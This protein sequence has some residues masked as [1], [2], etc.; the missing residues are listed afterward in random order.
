MSTLVT[1]EDAVQEVSKVKI[2][3][4]Y[5]AETGAAHLTPGKPNCNSVRF[6]NMCTQ[7]DRFIVWMK[8]DRHV[9]RAG[10]Q[11]KALGK[12]KRSEV[13]EESSDPKPS[14]EK[15]VDSAEC[16]LTVS[17]FLHQIAN[18]SSDGSVSNTTAAENPENGQSTAGG[19]AT[20]TQASM[21]CVRK[22]LAINPNLL[23]GQ[24][25]EVPEK[26]SKEVRIDL[27]VLALQLLTNIDR[28]SDVNETLAAHTKSLKAVRAIAL[29]LSGLIR[30]ALKANVS[31]PEQK[32]KGSLVVGKIVKDPQSSL[33]VTDDDGNVK[34][35]DTRDTPMY[36]SFDKWLIE[37]VKKH[38]EASS[39]SAVTPRRSAKKGRT[40]TLTFN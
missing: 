38:H 40:Q 18:N 36:I 12:R 20:I 6:V 26:E 5:D 1:V 32:A 22:L 31:L 13:I 34:P 33:F 2:G 35:L 16:T 9:V 27:H 15:T 19:K 28:L 23:V 4:L 8:Y 10:S 14:N 30:E 3:D 29:G 37:Y 24:V 25:P 21:D 17:S 7:S 11:G 39:T